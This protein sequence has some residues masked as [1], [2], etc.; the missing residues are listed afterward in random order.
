[1]VRSWPKAEGALSSQPSG[2]ADTALAAAGLSLPNAQ[3]GYQQRWCHTDI[4]NQGVDLNVIAT[5]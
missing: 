2:K 1:M 5:G 4:R 3:P